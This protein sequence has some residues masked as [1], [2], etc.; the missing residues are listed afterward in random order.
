M[1]YSDGHRK[2]EKND[3]EIFIEVWRDQERG[4][5][6]SRKV[7]DKISK[8]YNDSVFGGASWSNDETKVAFIAERS[9]LTYKNH[10]ED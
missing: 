1:D 3:K 8:I 9:D 7:N 5:S 4:I 6:S 10:W 2:G